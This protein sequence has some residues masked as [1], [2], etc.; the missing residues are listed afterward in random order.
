MGTGQR[1]VLF[2]G[3]VLVL[4]GI[5]IGVRPLGHA[6]GWATTL[7][8]TV[9]PTPPATVP[10]EPGYQAPTNA[11]GQGP[12]PSNTYDLGSGATQYLDRNCGSAFFP[13]SYD[14]GV[15]VPSTSQRAIPAGVTEG[16][17]KVPPCSGRLSTWRYPAV[18]LLVAGAI[19]ALVGFF[20]FRPRKRH[21][22]DTVSV[23]Q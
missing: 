20:I 5:G 9:P 4:A 6:T 10:Y 1:V 13:A 8:C 19:V 17:S 11:I 15:Y 3:L 12:C 22:A 2:V 7:Y 14:S 21:P 18:A 16:W 23:P